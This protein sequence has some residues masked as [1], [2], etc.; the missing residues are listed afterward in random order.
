LEELYVLTGADHTH[1][2]PL[3]RFLMSMME[4]EPQVRTIVYDLGLT[5]HQRTVAALLV[6][7]G[8][9]RRFDFTAHPAYFDISV[10]A[11]E[12]A[13][14]PAI[15]ADE[16]A[17]RQAPA[18]WMDAGN[19]LAGSLDVVRQKLSVNGFYCPSSGFSAQPWTHP[20]MLSYFG[21]S[22]D[23]GADIMQLS[24]ATVA[25][26]P[27]FP[28]ALA[29]ATAW[30]RLAGVQEVIAPPGSDRS[31]HR[32]DQALLT[33]LAFDRGMLADPPEQLPPEILIQQ[34]NPTN[35]LKGAIRQLESELEFALYE[36]NTSRLETERALSQLDATLEELRAAGKDRDLALEGAERLR[37]EIERTRGLFD[38]EVQRLNLERSA[39]FEAVRSKSEE[40][41]ILRN[42]ASWR[43]TAPL[44]RARELITARQRR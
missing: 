10:N 14:K 24:G 12:Y 38:I 13:W 32:Q 1:G 5:E 40:I 29:L 22:Q 44:R 9:L 3:I 39:A 35:V 27:K 11:G 21:F 19:L 16:I 18:L 34:D 4:H 28:K 37:S 2:E 8:D 20:G 41:D 7:R 36:R 31:N 33:C 23:W 26:D 6:G 15:I 25:F 42:S 17:L 43:V 30:S